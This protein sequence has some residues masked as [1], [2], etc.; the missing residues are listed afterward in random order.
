MLVLFTYRLE[1]VGAI[2]DYDRLVDIVL[3][4]HQRNLSGADIPQVDQR[5]ILDFQ[6]VDD[7]GFLHY[8]NIWGDGIFVEFIIFYMWI[9]A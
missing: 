9:D 2:V 3:G 5:L 1:G 6:K 4:L 8:I 7:L